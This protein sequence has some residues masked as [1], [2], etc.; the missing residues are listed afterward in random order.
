MTFKDL[1]SFGSISNICHAHCFYSIGS[2][3]VDHLA[4][5]NFT[6]LADTTE[7]IAEVMGNTL[8]LGWAG[9]TFELY[10]KPFFVQPV[11]V[12]MNVT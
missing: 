1:S 7:A 12:V 4:I 11:A 9:E 6:V 8:L 3:E 2:V 5:V 10:T